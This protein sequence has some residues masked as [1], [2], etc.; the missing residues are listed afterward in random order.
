METDTTPSL[1]SSIAFLHVT[2]PKGVTITE[3][4]RVLEVGFAEKIT[5]LNRLSEIAL[6]AKTLTFDLHG[7]PVSLSIR[8]LTSLEA[9]AQDAMAEPIPPRKPKLDA[10]GRPAADG[11]TELDWENADFRRKSAELFELKRAITIATGLVGVQVPGNTPV[12]QK[13]NLKKLFPPQVLGLV[14]DSILA[15]T[16][17]ALEIASFT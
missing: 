9:A 12:E 10:K 16:N 11:S 17:K 1:E 6:G 15:L 5:D 2:Y 7:S 13:D 14:Y 8:G 4:G 3:D